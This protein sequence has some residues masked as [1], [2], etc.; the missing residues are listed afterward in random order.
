MGKDIYKID[1]ICEALEA[2]S[3]WVKHETAK[4]AQSIEIAEFG[5]AVDALKDLSEAKK[6]CMEACYYEKV[7][8]AMEEGVDAVYGYNNRHY[9]NGEFAPRGRGSMM[10][11]KPYMDQ[12]PYIDAYLHDPDFKR[13]MSRMGYAD[14][15]RTMEHPRYGK[16]YN[17]YLEA[18][19]HYTSTN[20]MKDKEEMN[21]Y[22]NEHLN[23]TIASFRDIWKN[24]DVDLKR[25]FKLDLTSLLNNEMQI[26]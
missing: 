22:A 4:G 23:D 2:L 25:K 9:K 17:E 26:A 7:I 16:A 24:S 6:N 14:T 8:E 20:S 19:K 21:S 18:R 10:G 15:T 12:E 3:K 5:Q 13:N 11:Y 1:D